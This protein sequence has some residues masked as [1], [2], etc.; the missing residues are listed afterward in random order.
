MHSNITTL[1]AEGQME[2]EDRMD[3]V[4]R[5]DFEQLQISNTQFTTALAEGIRAVV[6]HKRRVMNATTQLNREMSNIK[7][8][9]KVNTDLQTQIHALYGAPYF[10]WFSRIWNFRMLVGPTLA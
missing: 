7:K 4:T 5:V 3:S 6:D 1:Q 9:T 2:Q 10:V 8:T